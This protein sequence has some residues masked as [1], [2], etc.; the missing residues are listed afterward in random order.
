MYMYFKM[1]LL[2]IV[3]ATYPN[4]RLPFPPLKPIYTSY[5]LGH[6]MCTSSITLG[7]PFPY[8]HD[9]LKQVSNSSHAKRK[10]LQQ[11]AAMGKRSVL[12]NDQLQFRSQGRPRRRGGSDLRGQLRLVETLQSKLDEIWMSGDGQSDMEEWEV[13]DN[14]E[15]CANLEETGLEI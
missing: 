14:V 10:S 3:F 5:F 7:R 2:I 15:Y 13:G 6:L 12:Y 1:L 4:F 9:S 11:L 8:S